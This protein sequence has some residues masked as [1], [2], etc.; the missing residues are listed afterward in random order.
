MVSLKKLILLG[1][2]GLLLVGCG[3]SK[4][5]TYTLTEK[6]TYLEKA[7]SGDKEARQFIVERMNEAEKI[8]K[9]TAGD[10]TAYNEW[11][12]WMKVYHGLRK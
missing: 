1:T 8:Y 5:K 10:E 7:N 11:Q 2:L 12:Q 9:E 4:I 3:R 6:D